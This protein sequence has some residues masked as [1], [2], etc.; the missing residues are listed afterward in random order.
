MS[1]EKVLMLVS[2]DPHV[3]LPLILSKAWAYLLSCKE[4]SIPR[5]ISSSGG[6]CGGVAGKMFR[7]P[8]PKLIADGAGEVMV[9]VAARRGMEI[10]CGLEGLEVTV[11]ACLI[12][13][14]T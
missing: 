11:V 9:V 4:A 8:D 12:H 13:F 1:G 7:F 3:F 10:S 5:P 14:S 2:V 6:V